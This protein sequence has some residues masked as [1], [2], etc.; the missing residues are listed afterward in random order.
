MTKTIDPDAAAELFELEDDDSRGYGGFFR[1]A[2][3]HV[4]TAR[5]E[6]IYYLV[7]SEAET[8]DV[9]GLEY[10]QGLTESQETEYPWEESEAPLSLV[11]LYP[12]E[13]TTVEYRTRPAGAT[14]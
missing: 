10:R 6:E 7:L 5:W 1:V 8:G 14:A 2:S 12:H 3:Q 9:Y 11:R 4:R 13:V